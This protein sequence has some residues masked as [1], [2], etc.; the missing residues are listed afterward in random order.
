MKNE[1]VNP[2]GAILLAHGAGLPMDSAFMTDISVRLAE[3]GLT[4]LRL[5]FPYM[6]K[7]RLGGP[8]RP[9]P[10]AEKLCDFYSD[11][12]TEVRAELPCKMPLFIGGKSLGGR[13]ASMVADVG[14]STAQTQGLVCLG[15]PFHPPKK[16]EDLRTGHLKT[17]ACP[18]LIC[19]G[20]RDPLGSSQEIGSYVLDRRIAFH[21]VHD[22][23]HDFKPRK[24]S[25]LTQGENLEDAA[26]AVASFA[27]SLC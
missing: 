8:K 18:T 15:Y 16:P 20:E 2:F 11:V 14:F 1:A 24:R 23:D 6:A 22:G 12:M 4:V 25:G 13:V 3:Q 5:E 7:R 17:I 10:K 21:W 19:Q 27:R 26:K 9:P